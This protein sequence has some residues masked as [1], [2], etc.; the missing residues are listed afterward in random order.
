MNQ[1]EK[2]GAEGDE[3]KRYMDDLKSKMQHVETLMHDDEDRQ[4]D[5]L[6][7]KMEARKARRKKLEDRLADVEE[8]I[9]A[10]DK[11]KVQM[12]EQKLVEI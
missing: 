1:L 8:V 2:Y 4:N 3:V 10:S 9:N 11:E 6:R 5:V 7:M 12:Q